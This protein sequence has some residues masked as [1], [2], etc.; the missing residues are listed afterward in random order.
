LQT[1]RYSFS[2]VNVTIWQLKLVNDRLKLVE[3]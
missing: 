2:E 1:Q 3:G